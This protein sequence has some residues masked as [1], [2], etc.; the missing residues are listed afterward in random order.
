M[1]DDSVPDSNPAH[2]DPAALMADLIEEATFELENNRDIDELREFIEAAENGELGE[3]E[4]GV[5]A[6]VRMARSILEDVDG[7]ESAEE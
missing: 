7:D 1:T 4:P 2:F 6:Q 3:I 5:E